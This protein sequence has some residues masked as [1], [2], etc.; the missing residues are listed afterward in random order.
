MSPR[1]RL[2]LIPTGRFG[3]VTDNRPTARPGTRQCLLTIT[4]PDRA[5]V[6]DP[7]DR[8]R[9]SGPAMMGEPGEQPW[10]WGPSPT[11]TATCGR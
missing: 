3:W 11:P 1:A 9:T 2:M 5:A 8:A 4:V 6:V 7:V 10:G